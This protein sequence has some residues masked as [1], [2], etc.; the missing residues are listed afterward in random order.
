MP[1]S[2]GHSREQSTVPTIKQHRAAAARHLRAYR[3]TVN[4][5]PDWGAIMLFYAAL[6]YVEAA[7]E[8]QGHHHQS[9]SER[10]FSIR[11]SHA[12]VWPAYARLKNESMKAR[13]LHGGRFALNGRSVDQEL[14]RGKLA[15]IRHYL[16]GLLGGQRRQ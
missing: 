11:E 15:V 13:Y 7:F 16:S 4:R 12:Q 10:D 1:S 2:T 3:A 9:H 6:H 8:A 14:R 5:F